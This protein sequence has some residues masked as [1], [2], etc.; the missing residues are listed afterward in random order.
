MKKGFTLIEL[1]IA[2][3][4]FS[5]LT[6]FVALTFLVGLRVWGSGR[7]RAEITQDGILSIER[8]VRELGQ[9]S[10]IRSAQADRVR[11]DADL[12][13]DGSDETITF[14]VSGGVLERTE[15]GGA[16]IDLAPNVGNF[17]LSY[18]TSNS[19]PMV[20]DPMPF[21]VTGPQLDTVRVIAISLTL[22]QA[23]EAIT[24]SSS[25]YTRN[26]SDD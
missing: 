3:A 21:P 16:Q 13:S 10:E 12:N 26:Q 14:A 4:L 9:A 20:D 8:M 24:L 23:D 25:A 11:F 17:A 22:E 2:V 1:I 19:D 7:E 6:V 15:Q 5:I 18:Y